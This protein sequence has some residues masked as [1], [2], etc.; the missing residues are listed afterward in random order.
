MLDKSI[1]KRQKNGRDNILYSVKGKHMYKG[2]SIT[3]SQKELEENSKVL[4]LGIVGENVGIIS[5]RKGNEKSDSLKRR[6][7]IGNSLDMKLPRITEAVSQDRGS[8][9]RN[10]NSIDNIQLPNLNQY[11]HGKYFLNSQK[12]NNSK[13][14]NPSNYR[15]RKYGSIYKIK[16]NLALNKS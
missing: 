16:L 1:V 13:L 4:N 6:M 14:E 8:Y 5:T 15:Y 11:N 12:A 3:N 7:Q 9:L 10:Q 2:T